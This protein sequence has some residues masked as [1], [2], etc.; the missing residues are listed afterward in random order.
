MEIHIGNCNTSSR[1][2]IASCLASVDS[3][4]S[5]LG[6]YDGSTI[7]GYRLYR[8]VKNGGSKTRMKGK[9]CLAPPPTCSQWETVATSLEEFRAVVVRR[10][11]LVLGLCIFCPFCFIKHI[12]LFSLD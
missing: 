4:Y 12:I 10:Q 8:E 6:R 11:F 9:A 1:F 2:H 3:F 7:I 5:I